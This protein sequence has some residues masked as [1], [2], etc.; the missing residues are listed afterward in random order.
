LGARG[1]RTRVAGGRQP[2]SRIS[3]ERRDPGGRLLIADD[4]SGRTGW[5][6]K[7]QDMYLWRR[8]ASR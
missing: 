7:L 5:T 2:A 3:T 6:R 4:L 1:E 8:S